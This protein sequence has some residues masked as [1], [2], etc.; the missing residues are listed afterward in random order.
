MTSSATMYAGRRSRFVVMTCGLAALLAV[1]GPLS[2]NVAFGQQAASPE[3]TAQAAASEPAEWLPP[4]PMRGFERRGPHRDAPGAPSEALNDESMWQLLQEFYPER[5]SQ[6]KAL[7]EKDP[8]KFAQMER[9]MRPRLRELRDA[10]AENP[11]LAE[12]MLR[13][14]HNE[15]EIHN[16]H[17]RYSAAS[18]EDRQTL[19]DEGRKLIQTRVDL[20]LQREQM[21]IQMLEKRLQDLKTG[22]AERDAHKN[23]MVDRELAAISN[24]SAPSAGKTSSKKPPAAP[25]TAPSSE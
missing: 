20:R 18:G 11:K 21:R 24:P 25:A 19:L 13:Q 9:E 23:E 12:L 5:V 4:P 7:R 2:L 3:V 14:H 6:L 22:L 8:H 16:W 1:A 15:M 17:G 10:R